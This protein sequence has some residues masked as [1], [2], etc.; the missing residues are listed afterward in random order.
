MTGRVQSIDALR[1]ITIF[2]MIFCAAISYGAGLPA[3][4]FHCQVPPPDYVFHPE[5]RGITWV[6]MI[7]PFFIF[8]MGAA[9]PFS[10][11][12]KIEKG[13]S[14]LSIS[15]G[16]IR[17]WAVLVAFGLAI[18]HA[19]ALGRSNLP[20]EAIAWVR[21]GLWA[22][23]FA[24]LVKTKR[25]WINI[26]GWVLLAG[27]FLLLHFCCG[28]PL[29]TSQNDCIIIL[30][31]A[32]A[33]L[34]GFI[35]LY[36]RNSRHL[37][38]L[39]WALIIC[40]K[41]IGWDWGMYLVIALPATIVGDMLLDRDASVPRGAAAWLG[42]AAVVLQ[43]WGLFTRHVLIDGI[44]TLALAAG[45]FLLTRRDRGQM[46]N[47]GWMGFV[48]LLAGIAFD[49]LDGG[50]AKDYCN[51]SYLLVTAGQASLVLYFLLWIESRRSLSLNFTTLGRNPMI[52]YTIPWFVISPL[53]YGVGLMG[54]IDSWCGTPVLGL[55]PGL[56][57]TLAMMALTCLCTRLKI[58]WKS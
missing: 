45:F 50:I 13:E 57:V 27:A 53:L 4:M 2:A 21:F 7:F 49:P 8:A 30:L 15:L 20:H 44:V 33:L 24:A 36:T 19:D 48:L 55:V 34:G 17:R 47:L 29:S 23:M 22:L 38:I 28:L 11:S 46:S 42:L 10:L 51:M 43:L 31:S 1:G 41:L 14:L 56:V 54:W 39:C 12:R 25:V 26:V 52:A 9:I 16:I 32:V 40:T 6:D 58:F 5:V 18:G 37:R 3:W 35:W